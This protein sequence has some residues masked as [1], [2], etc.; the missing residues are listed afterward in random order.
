VKLLRVLEDRQIQPAGKNRSVSSDFR[1]IAA[2]TRDLRTEVK[3]GRFRAD[4]FHR[5]N[6]IPLY[7]AR[8]RKRPLS[9][10]R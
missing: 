4:L 5:L 9:I 7:V 8:S 6:L 1:L 10:S 2:A 3:E